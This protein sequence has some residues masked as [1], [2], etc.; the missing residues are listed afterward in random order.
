LAHKKNNYKDKLKK[1][2]LV[3]TDVD[4]VLTDGSR[5]YNE[6][7]ELM[8]KFHTVDGMGVNMLL[9]KGIKTVILTKE[10]SNI[11]LKWAKD[12]NVTKVFS[13]SVEKE[14]TLEEILAKFNVKAVECAYIGDDVNDVK[15]LNKVGFSACPSDANIV[16]LSIVDRIC[17]KKG[18]RGVFREISDLILQT[19]F[20]KDGILYNPK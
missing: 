15:V 12:M 5:Y 2:K 9:R 4:G 14:K 10:K 16:V 17:N 18:G 19:K 11:V 6:K 8:K 20:P 7:V 3:I 13:G 1:I